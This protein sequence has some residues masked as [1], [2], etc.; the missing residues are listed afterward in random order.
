VSKQ[1]AREFL[2]AID[3]D[4][5]LQAA[6]L[7]TIPTKLPNNSPIVAFARQHGFEFTE[8]E[9]HEAAT[10]VAAGELSEEQLDAV[11]GGTEG[12]VDMDGS[13]AY[14]GQT[15]AG[16]FSFKASG[17][18]SSGDHTVTG[19]YSIGGVTYSISKDHATGLLGGA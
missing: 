15:Y 12:N 17:Q 4:A 14:E 2:R 11:S 10:S 16:G 8:R 7:L 19:T 9:F 3:E 18:R 5:A 1:A 13:I 6:F